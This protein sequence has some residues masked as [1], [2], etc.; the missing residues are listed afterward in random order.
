MHIFII[1]TKLFK[2]LSS[3]LNIIFATKVT[4]IESL[5]LKHFPH[6]KIIFLIKAVQYLVR[7][8]LSMQTKSIC[9]PI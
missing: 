9:F 3:H 1:F 8:T 6:F 2:M 5:F 7:F 4:N